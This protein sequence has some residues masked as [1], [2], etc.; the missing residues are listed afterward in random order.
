MSILRAGALILLLLAG[1]VIG[2]P[3]Q[4]A[5]RLLRPGWAGAMQSYFCRLLLPLLGMR[6]RV[7]GA[8]AAGAF[9]VVNHISWLD[10]I[11]L[12]AA[13]PCVFVA[14]S[15]VA[16]WPVFGALAR[17]QR[18]IFVDR[19]DRSAL[20]AV[21]DAIAAALKQ[22]ACVVLFAEGTS[23]DGTQV[24]P[25]KP[26]HFAPAI[27]ARAQVAPAAIGY[28]E[29]GA[30]SRRPAW[31]GDMDFVSHVWAILRGAPYECRLLF[32]PA[33][34]SV[35]LERKALAACCENIV[36]QLVGENQAASRVEKYSI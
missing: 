12:G 30:A 24:L 26:A 34:S 7:A 29:K 2:V 10:V 14:K 5:F 3:I 31:Y 27:A 36:R 11:A 15:Q 8:P 33:V 22:G 23:S 1:L 21:N 20:S 17:S 28:F 32:G 18:T 16:S 13:R 35:G 9:I 4:A 6:L 19:S 25:F